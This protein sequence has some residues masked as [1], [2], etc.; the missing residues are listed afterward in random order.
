MTV[1]FPPEFGAARYVSLTTF[2]SD[3]SPVATPVWVVEK[4]GRLFVWT[5]AA[6]GKARRI[7]RDPRARVAVCD[8]RG[9]LDEG[10]GARGGGIARGVGAD[11][12]GNAG[13]ATAT[14]SGVLA[15]GRLL[16]RDDRL[17]VWAL[18]RRKYGWQLRGTL[19][20]GR[21]NAKLRRRPAD[22]SSQVFIEL[23]PM[24]V[25][26]ADASGGEPSAESAPS[27]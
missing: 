19:L 5:G 12:D 14:A 8:Y 7:R 25:A 4:E 26:A 9:R 13:S 11:G 1:H 27:D 6:T 15:L 23:R 16:P 3:G 21:V 20:S 10:G 2:R 22:P 24:T 17:D 18:M